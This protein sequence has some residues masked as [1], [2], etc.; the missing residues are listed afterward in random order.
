MTTDEVLQRVVVP[1]PNDSDAMEQVASFLGASLQ[2][3][4]AQ[5]SREAFVAT[6]HGFE[7]VFAA[8][9]AIAAGY[10]I[11]LALGRHRLALVLL[12]GAAGLLLAEFELLWSPL[13][14]LAP[15]TLHNV[16]GTFSGRAGGPRLVFV[17]HYD[18][19]TH[20]GNHATWGPTG[21][22]LGPAVGLVIALALLGIARAARGRSRPPRALGLL[23]VAPFAAMAWF[24]RRA[25]RCAKRVPARSTTVVRSS[26][27]C[28]W[29][30][31]SPRDP[32]MLPPRATR[33]QR[34][35]R[36]TRLRLAGTRSDTAAR[37]AGC[38]S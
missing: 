31:A 20:F 36:R 23:V 8:A 33:L 34:R 22:V 37:R 18:T 30:G 25:L 28:K 24:H 26:R 2:G 12:L 32:M 15:A 19:T 16:V 14:G 13:S 7:I 9:F 5:V 10:A 4:G 11:A 3:Q 29:R 38:P 6:P 17:A 35:R 1:R 27:F 21:F